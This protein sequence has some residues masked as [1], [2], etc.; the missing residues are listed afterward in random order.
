MR[1]SLC[2]TRSVGSGDPLEVVH[3]AGGAAVDALVQVLHRQADDAVLGV[4]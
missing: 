2:L 1:C 3:G 4:S